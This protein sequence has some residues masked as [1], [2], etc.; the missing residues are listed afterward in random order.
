M[1]I[2]DFEKEISEMRDI[3]FDA[4]D[5]ANFN[6][7]VSIKKESTRIFYNYYIE[8][9]SKVPKRDRKIFYDYINY[10]IY[11]ISEYIIEK[12]IDWGRG[13]YLCIRKTMRKFIKYI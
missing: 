7:M 5:N 1:T 8:N 6:E 4:I 13:D 11:I 10:Q 2:T 9:L 12:I 3:F